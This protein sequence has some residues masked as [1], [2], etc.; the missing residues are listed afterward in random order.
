[1]RPVEQSFDAFVAA[2]GP[3]LLRLA[4]VMT[5][6]VHTAEDITQTTLLRMHRAGGRSGTRIRTHG[7][8]SPM[9]R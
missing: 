1:M 2:R 5:G 8:R 4:Y 3:Q 9:A 6:E 7:R